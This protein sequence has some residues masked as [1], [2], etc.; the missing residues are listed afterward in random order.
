M[1]RQKAVIQPAKETEQHVS[2]AQEQSRQSFGQTSNPS[3]ESS[4][5]RD[6]PSVGDKFFED[7]NW[8]P[9]RV[10]AW[11]SANA[12]SKEWQ[13]AFQHL[14][15]YG[16]QFLDIGRSGGQR[17]IPFMSQTVL[18]Q[19]AREC[20]LNGI[21]WDQAKERDH[22]KRLRKLVKDM[23]KSGGAT[24]SAT[25]WAANG[26]SS[27]PPR[28]KRES[29]SF[30]GSV[31][32]GT[33]GGV[34]NSPSTLRPDANIFGSNS[35][36]SGNGDVSPGVATSQRQFSGQRSNATDMFNS[37]V[38]ESGRSQ[39]SHSAL[40]GIENISR[41]NSP[42][43]SLDR[44]PQS[45]PGLTFAHPLTN[46]NG[47]G[48]GRHY[49]AH[50]RGN[51]S[52]TNVVL[53]NH[54]SNN[55]R[56]TSGLTM[57]N[58]NSLL[59][60]QSKDSSTL[61][62][63]RLATDNRLRSSGS[64]TPISARERTKNRWPFRRDRKREDGV[65]QSPDG[66]P[67]SPQLS[68]QLPYAR[69]SHASSESSL[70]NRPWT[71][72]ESQDRFPRGRP[73]ARD[74]TKKFIFVTPDGW[75]YRLIDISDIES[76][77]QL[78]TVICFNLG[79]MEGPNVTIHVTSPGQIEHE[80]DLTDQS[81]M[82]ARTQLADSTGSL[83]LYVR[84]SNS[85]GG[86]PEGSSLTLPAFPSSPMRKALLA[87]RT[88]D[89]SAPR[90]HSTSAVRSSITTLE[91]PQ[92]DGEGNANSD[93]MREQQGMLERD[94]QNLPEH[95]RQA[96][97]DA[98]AA[99]HRKNT[100]QKRSAFDRRGSRVVGQDGKVI[101]D[102]D[103]K[104]SSYQGERDDESRPLSSGSIDFE[105]KTDSFQPMRR[106]PPVPEPTSTLVKANSLTKKTSTNS[107]GSWPNRKEDSWKRISGGSIPEENGKKLAKLGTLAALKT[108]EIGRK[109]ESATSAPAPAVGIS[110]STTAPDVL[111]GSMATMKFR[112]AEQAKSA[113]P[114][115][116]YTN[117]KGGQT[118]RIPDYIESDEQV[119]D[120][121]DTLKANKRQILSPQKPSHLTVQTISN[122]HR[123]YSPDVSPGTAHP[124]SGGSLGRVS[125]KRGPSFDVPEQQIDF[126]RASVTFSDKSEDSDDGL[127][128][129]PIV[130][131]KSSPMP[132]P[133]P[134]KAAKVLGVGADTPIRSPNRP[135]LTLRTSKPDRKY[136]SPKFSTFDSID[137]NMDTT[138]Q[139]YGPYSTSS[140]HPWSNDSPDDTVRLDRRESFQRDLWAN[141]PPVEGIAEHLDEFFPNVDLD[142]PMGDDVDGVD[143]SPDLTD[144]SIL[145]S[146]SSSSDM[147]TSRTNTPPSSTDETLGNGQSTFKRGDANVVAQRSIRK[148]GV[149]GR[150]KSIRDVVKNNYQPF[151][152]SQYSVSSVASSRH[153]SAQGPPPPSTNLQVLPNRVNTLKTEGGILRRKSTKMFGAK[154]QQVKPQRGSRLINNLDPIPQ[155][156]SQVGNGQGFRPGRKPTFKWMRGQ[157]IGKGTFGKVYLGMNTTTGEL[158]AVKQ[159]E[160]NP[161]SQNADPA[162]VRE[163]VKALDQEIDTM[164]H[165]DHVN[166]VQYLG[167]ERKEYS[168]CIFLEY[169]SGGSVG[170]CLR[171]HG[172]FEEPV[173]S[174]LTRQTLGGLAYLHSEGILH[175]DLKADN[176][177]LDLD[178]TCKI[179]DFGIS[180]R[181]A[182]PYNNDITNS[183][184]GS[185]FW[186][187]P[188][189][190]RAQSQGLSMTGSNGLDAQS[191]NQGYSAK[192][193]I[194]SLGCV[195]LEMFA[196]RR[197]WSKEEAIG[198]IYK[199]G[200]LNQAPPIP[201]DVGTVVG[202]AA[203]SFMYDCFTM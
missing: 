141:R 114:R 202:P 4:A 26:T 42:S 182:N 185:V 78:K 158:L 176:I 126:R 60:D 163:M 31:S 200:S 172:K 124:P 196:G 104:G 133:V 73:V 106:P 77:E 177:L 198:A 9:E 21:V 107:R 156:N 11:L 57:N 105:R 117:S 76:A 35:S 165:L 39:F 62:D 12:F 53:N 118:F 197:P 84:T 94:F 140:A 152:T 74:S 187:A 183:M 88:V 135:N 147:N 41:T 128:A 16:G 10:Q 50:I 90:S 121:E 153:V 24:T 52:D 102:F 28:A 119:T 96:L 113:S 97:L 191:M 46:G 33:E 72:G 40:A 123:S 125:S 20:T 145:A 63:S 175:R 136:D 25:S 110:R 164:Q 37:Y 80:E 6:H 34:E 44:A 1:A 48:Q 167:C 64:E 139:I 95:E 92:T 171:K 68:K 98:K 144:R 8:P 7:Q 22:S 149:L 146:G 132:G 120:D 56:L 201:D 81:L 19:V 130:S 111:N 100:E 109:N 142:Q 93:K 14:N 61:D 112:T 101:H 108:A 186:M 199:L 129:I 79:I 85:T 5:N 29:N 3:N 180:K 15:V 157:M 89:N 131:Q 194:W 137:E 70:T 59:E 43:D 193:D 162:K 23:I 2:P 30:L 150:T 181:S 166:I 45:S 178:G 184:Q 116:P 55:N 190:I 18:P 143:G 91:P 160:V 32:A 151:K 103:Y 71:R 65:Q 203:L 189:V 27:A 67:S 99:E 36:L 174:S 159:V 173:V 115:S 169:I 69:T 87:N 75:N 161:K 38:N 122:S 170:S 66:E 154:I 155:D 83:K 51:S 58:E 179:S 188:E 47:A 192:V 13:A 17:N 86:L 134:S 127:F 49:G 82:S 54:S 168:I 148:S 138:D 195:V